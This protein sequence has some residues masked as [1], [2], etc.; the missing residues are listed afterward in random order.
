MATCGSFKYFPKNAL[1]SCCRNVKSA[2]RWQ[3]SPRAICRVIDVVFL[4][5]SSHTRLQEFSVINRPSIQVFCYKIFTMLWYDTSCCH[6]CVQSSMSSPLHHL[7]YCRLTL[8]I[9]LQAPV[10]LSWCFC[11]SLCAAPL[12][13]LYSRLKSS[14]SSAG[15]PSS[16]LSQIIFKSNVFMT[17]LFSTITHAHMWTHTHTQTYT[18]SAHREAWQEPSSGAWLAGWQRWR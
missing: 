2:V 12:P 11:T 13:L 14:I 1:L 9:R 5:L 4:C 17:K 3:L 10:S 15:H 6:L 18:I 8:L 7:S 16:V